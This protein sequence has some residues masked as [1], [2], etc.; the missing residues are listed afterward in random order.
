MIIAGVGHGAGEDPPFEFVK[1]EPRL[2][3]VDARINNRIYSI[4][5][6]LSSRP[7]PRIVDALEKF[8]ELIHPEL[9]KEK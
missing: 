4:D 9:F 7:G 1:T 6:D 2:R 3:N 8:A 5:A